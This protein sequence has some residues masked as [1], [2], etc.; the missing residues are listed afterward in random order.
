MKNEKNTAG[1]SV[2]KPGTSGQL[3]MSKVSTYTVDGRR[4]IVTPVF[5]ESGRE[6]F[7]SVLMRLMK[8]DVCVQP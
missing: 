2:Q 1:G 7:G 8:A 4:F 6:S 3:N 5:H